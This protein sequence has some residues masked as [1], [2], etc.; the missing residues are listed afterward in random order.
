MSVQQ[1]VECA[2]DHDTCATGGIENDAYWYV[3]SNPLELESMYSYY[4]KRHDHSCKYYP[5]DGRIGVETA[6][7]VPPNDIY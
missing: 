4:G 7:S 5:K 2:Y 6:Y 3:K 1:L